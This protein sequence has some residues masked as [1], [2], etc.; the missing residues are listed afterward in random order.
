MVDRLNGLRHDAVV[1]CNNQDGNIGDVRSTG[2]HGGERLMSRSIQ[3]GNQLAVDV[4]L[5]CTDVLG[6]AARLG[7][8]D[9]GVADCV[10]DGGLAVVDVTHNN[11][12]RWALYLL[13]ILVLAVVKQTVLD[14]DDNFFFYLSTDFHC[15]QRSG[16]V[17]DDV[18][19]RL[20]LAEHHQ[21]LYN[22]CRLD[23]QLVGQFSNGDLVRE[24]D[25]QFLAALTLDFQPF[26]LLH[27]LVLFGHEVL[28]LVV[29][30]ANF[31]FLDAVI[32]SSH[33][34]RRDVLIALVVF[35][36]IDI[37]CT[38][39]DVA[40]DLSVDVLVELR[41]D[42]G[43]LPR[44]W[45]LFWCLRFWLRLRVIL[46]LVAK[47]AAAIVVAV[48]VVAAVAVIKAALALWLSVAKSAA[49]IIV[50][51]VAAAVAV[52][53]V[54]VHSRTIVAAAVITVVRTIFV[55]ALGAVLAPIVVCSG[56]SAIVAARFRRCTLRCLAHILVLPLCLRL[57]SLHWRLPILLWLRS[58]LHSFW[59]RLRMDWLRL[60]FLFFQLLCLVCFLNLFCFIFLWLFLRLFFWLFLWFCRLLFRGGLFLAYR[61]GRNLVRIIVV[62]VVLL[63][64]L[65][66]GLKHKVEL[67]ICQHG[68]AFF[69]SRKVFFQ[70]IDD[71]L[72]LHIQ[73]FS[74]L[75]DS[76]FI[77][78][79]E[80][81]RL[82]LFRNAF[83]L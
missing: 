34:F 79:H 63:V 26:E 83:V 6:N 21:A 66:I 33:I 44:S 14:G 43:R 28:F 71:V 76:I 57:L 10:E 58:L 31:L 8:G 5:I 51:V 29:S 53:A 17:V 48:A 16:I 49:A 56:L 9:V 32:A 68:C 20:H 40:N 19:Y 18:G 23:L 74:N 30:A 65:C 67:L 46:S 37:G 22:L 38:H 27:L 2:T 73:I 55:A 82:L 81:I 11:N 75:A 3:E 64:L 42:G 61:L 45:R 59:F 41:I 47:S 80:N 72:H 25:A 12:D 24:G 39:I 50:A 35:V 69:L 78:Y 52:V 15:N 77:I 54:A 62:Q 7:G 36:Q 1:S 70:Q 4:D 60:F 13:F